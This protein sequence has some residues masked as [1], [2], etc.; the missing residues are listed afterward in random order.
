MT[1]PFTFATA[2]SPIPLSN[3]DNNFAALGT[4]NNVNY[5]APFASSVTRSVSSKLS[6]LISV[7]DFGA[8]PTGFLDS[9]TAINN[10]IAAVNNSG[11]LYI[12]SGSYLYSATTYVVGTDFIWTNSNFTTG[13]NV[14]S[15][16]RGNNIL[17][18]TQ[19]ST[20]TGAV[21][22]TQTKAGI[23]ITAIAQGSQHADG[24]RSNLTNKSTNGN[25]N[26]AFYGHAVSAQYGVFWSAALHGET[27]AAAGT[28]IG[29]NSES[30]QFATAYCTGGTISGTVLTVDSSSIGTWAVG[31]KISGTNVTSE[32]TITSLGTGTGG[33]GTYNLSASSTVSTPEAISGVS[34]GI[35]GA[36]INNVTAGGGTHPNLG[37]PIAQGTTAT[38]IYITGGY[39]NNPI[40]GWKYGIEFY[41]GSMTDNGT[42]IL[43][44]ATANV[45]SHIQTSTNSASSTADIFLQGN[46][47]AGIIL[48]G[49]YTSNAIRISTNSTIAWESTGSIRTK[50]DSSSAN[51]G[52][53]SN[54]TTQR[55][56]WL[57][58]PSPT[59]NFNGT[60]V[61]G[62]RQTGWTAMTGTA[63][64]ASTFDTSTVTLQQLAQRVKAIEDALI[65]HGLIGS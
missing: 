46:S 10:A 20:Q 61:V 21:D 7:L 22:P 52:I 37:T 30:H 54:N 63:D 14:M 49:T 48:S 59:M 16:A 55:V 31:Q 32:T 23:N 34:G 25:G 29:V 62:V 12:P 47:A 38:G 65:T 3:L 43:I 15:S 53:Y 57:I 39:A 36:V 13:V 27:Y 44:S 26:T 9:T 42:T 11:I 1:V 50:Y 41:S 8:D 33:A 64:K 60:Q 5:I 45:A 51:W 18:T 40:G 24:I 17:V 19:T 35:Y 2:T 56:S 6:D 4:S 28:N 58:S